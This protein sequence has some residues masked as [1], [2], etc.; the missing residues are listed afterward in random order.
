MKNQHI[1]DLKSAVPP[2]IR[3]EVYEELINIINQ[4]HYGKFGLDG[5][6]S[7]CLAL[8][9]VLWDLDNWDN[10]GPRD[11]DWVF[12]DTVIAFPEFN[13][14]IMDTIANIYTQQDRN[15]ERKRLLQEAILIV[16]EKIENGRD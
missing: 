12:M 10:F 5:D 11:E 14:E 2:E 3:M 4:A 15:N 13:K 7:L 16:K 9:C 1:P 6:F 8:P